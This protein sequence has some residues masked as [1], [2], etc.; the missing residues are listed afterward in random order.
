MIDLLYKTLKKKREIKMNLKNI[1]TLLILLTSINCNGIS[2][3]KLKYYDSNSENEQMLLLD[4]AKKFN[5]LIGCEAVT[6]EY[7]EKTKE[8]IIG[9]GI[10]EIQILESDVMNILAEKSAAAYGID[11]A[12]A[13][14]FFE[15]DDVFISRHK[16]TDC[17]YE[18]FGQCVYLKIDIVFFH[19]IGH[20]FGLMHS[21]NE[22]D[23]MNKIPANKHSAN[24]FIDFINQ[25]QTKTN[26]CDKKK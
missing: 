3:I 5:A 16:L 23:I 10:S 11:K 12:A 1:I 14:T 20:V 17:Y 13:V 21:E 4:S 22:S 9:N 26:I 25:L 15:D 7:V 6:L 24:D 19:E 18:E 8:A 2:K